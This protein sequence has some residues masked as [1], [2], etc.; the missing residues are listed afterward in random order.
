MSLRPVTGGLDFSRS[1][2]NPIAPEDMVHAS[3]AS[4]AIVHDGLARSPGSNA[5]QQTGELV[6][7]DFHG[8][9]KGN[10]GLWTVPSSKDPPAGDRKCVLPLHQPAEA[11]GSPQPWCSSVPADDGTITKR[12]ICA[13]RIQPGCPGTGA[14]MRE[15]SSIWIHRSCLN[16]QSTEARSGHTNR[17]PCPSECLEMPRGLGH[18]SGT[19]HFGRDLE[20]ASD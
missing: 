9:V 15:R 8:R 16:D 17:S 11:V 19:N 10:P 4:A 1:V 13:A 6:P 3:L 5:P 18:N 2:V 20:S 14:A 7:C 12:P